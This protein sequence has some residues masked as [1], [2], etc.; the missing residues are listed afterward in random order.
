MGVFKPLNFNYGNNDK[1][2]YI[3][4]CTI[5][6]NLCDGEFVYIRNLRSTEIRKMYFN[7]KIIISPLIGGLKVQVMR[8][9]EFVPITDET[10]SSLEEEHWRIKNYLMAETDIEAIKDL[11]TKLSVNELKLNNIRTFHKVAVN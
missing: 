9:Y 2:S 6:I 7:T 3:K 1:R 5:F 8:D 4:F 11:L 10:L